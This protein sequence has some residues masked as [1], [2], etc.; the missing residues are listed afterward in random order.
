MQPLFF[1]TAVGDSSTAAGVRS[2]AISV[3]SKAK[4]DDSIAIGA[5]TSSEIRGVSIGSGASAHYQGISVWL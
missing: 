4:A 2:V 3:N 5:N 1:A